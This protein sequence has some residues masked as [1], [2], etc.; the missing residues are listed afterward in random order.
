MP[1]GKSTREHKRSAPRKIAVAVITCSTSRFKKSRR[2][3][4]YD[5][6]SGDLLVRELTRADHVVAR[7][8]L[9]S[10]DRRML[11][12][13]LGSLFQDAGLDAIII[14]GGTGIASSDITV[15]VAEGM[16]TKKIDGFGE[17]FRH[18]SFKEIG[19]SAMI[20]RATAGIYR[21]KIVFCLPGS[22]DAVRLGMTR[23]IV[24]EILHLVKHAK[25]K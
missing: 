22:I 15:E 21:N 23:L 18:M 6:P 17:L 25:E 12:K 24:P 8:E 4:S 13:V 19:S 2:G 10:D 5:D 1:E 11:K 20:S 9:I 7:R 14:S 16:F 3:E